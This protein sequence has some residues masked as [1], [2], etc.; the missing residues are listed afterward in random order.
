MNFGAEKALKPMG[1]ESEMLEDGIPVLIGFGA[2]VS[3]RAD[4]VEGTCR[5]A[6][7]A[8][9]HMKGFRTLAVSSLYQT[10]PIGFKDQPWFI[11][12]VVLGE[13]ILSPQELLRALLDLETM[14]GRVRSMRWGPRPLDLDIIFYGDRIIRTDGLVVP[15]PRAHERRFVLEP[16]AEVCPHFVHPVLGMTVL[17]LLQCPEV[18][19]QDVQRWKPL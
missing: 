18:Q 17:E 13:T 7:K 10:E 12:G 19:S 2:N 15:H 3:T 9:S 11:N 6:V 8:L 4:G 14:F 16:T 1:K 5:D